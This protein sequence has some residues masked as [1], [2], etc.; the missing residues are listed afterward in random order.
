MKNVDDVIIIGAGA[1]G[2]I[3]SI[4]AARNG[5]SVRVVER[6]QRV[7]KKLLATG[8][9]RCNLTN[10]TVS[11]DNYHGAAPKFVS[12]VLQQFDRTKTLRFFEELG[13]A[14]RVEDEGK[15]FPLSDQASSV[16]DV[17]RYEMERLGVRIQCETIIQR[18][19][20]QDDA[21]TCFSSEGLQLK[22]HRVVVAT[23]GK[24]SPN[25]GSNGGGFRIAQGLGHTIVEPF[26]ALVP[27]KLEHPSLRQMQGVRVLAAVEALVDNVP[28]GRE[29][30]EVLFT[31]YGVS[32][33]PVLSLSRIVSAA[34]MTGSQCIL[35]VD[36][37]PQFSAKEFLSS[38]KNRIGAAA[39][40]SVEFSFVG[41]LNKRLIP[42]VLQESRLTDPKAPCV[43]LKDAD[44]ARIVSQLKGLLFQCT[45]TLSWM[46]SQ[47]TAGGVD[48][49]EVDRRTLQSQ[50][51]PGVFLTGEV[52]DVDGDSG[53]FNLQWAWSTG[54]IAGLHAVHGSSR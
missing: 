40:K 25:L 48:T 51:V 6:M 43:S 5:A 18:V 32:G 50:I 7:G 45:G 8:N 20:P 19:V 54:Y 41:L 14:W 10:E 23:G 29:T 28:Q 24:S 2:M 1:S 16:L 34:T 33:T 36:L 22:A 52:L 12:N 26:P 13:I 49:R 35:K 9:G 44:I 37:F 46:Y 17:L 27:V 4:V 21:F 30:G 39:D 11:A 15:I 47:V 42:V 38:I 3:A 53:G 31:E